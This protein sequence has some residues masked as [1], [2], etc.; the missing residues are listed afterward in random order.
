MMARILFAS[1]FGL[2][3]LVLV[4]LAGEGAVKAFL[5]RGVHL[6]ARFFLSTGEYLAASGVALLLAVLFAGITA[7]IAGW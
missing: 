3:T 4:W 1:F 6:P 2:V 5:R 7:A